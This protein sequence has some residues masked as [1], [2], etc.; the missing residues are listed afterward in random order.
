[1]KRRDFIVGMT[2][3]AGASAL[4]KVEQQLVAF[5]STQIGVDAPRLYPGI[6]DELLTLEQV[7]DLLMPGLYGV[8]QQY[9]D[10]LFMNIVADHETQN[11]LVVAYKPETRAFL[12]YALSHESLLD[13]KYKAQFAPSNLA[14]VGCIQQYTPEEVL[15]SEFPP[16]TDDELREY[17]YLPPKDVD[18]SS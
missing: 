10:S 11:L 17:G 13:G 2:A 14:L 6:G 12:G 7:R 16:P 3:L 9:G 8:R 4:P 1:M 18:R 5:P 15:A